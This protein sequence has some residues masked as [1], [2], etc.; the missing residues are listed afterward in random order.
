SCVSISLT[1]AFSDIQYSLVGKFRNRNRPL[2]F[3]GDQG[4]PDEPKNGGKSDVSKQTT[5]LQIKE[6]SQVVALFSY[7]AT[8]PEDLEF[9]EGDVILVLS[10][11]NEEWLEGECNGKVGIFP[12]A[13]VEEHR[14]TDLEST[15]RG[16]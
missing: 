6:G 11:V 1:A 5:E 8:Q 4:F 3:Q 15:A 10:M 13:F 12:R 9:T 14:T 7:E 16:I 2:L